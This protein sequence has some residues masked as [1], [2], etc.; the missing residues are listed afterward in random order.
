MKYLKKYKVFES[1]N[2]NF[3]WQVASESIDIITKILKLNNIKFK[4]S[5]LDEE[6]LENIDGDHD[7]GS[8][9]YIFEFIDLDGN[10]ISIH[11]A[12]QEKDSSE[13]ENDD[14]DFFTGQNVSVLLFN[15]N[16]P[17]EDGIYLECGKDLM[18]ELSKLE[19]PLPNWIKKI[20]ND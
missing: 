15:D 13:I 20:N 12:P 17:D 6:E 11:I 9:L 3:Y 8:E 4:H 2:N 16:T 10:G 19:L 18:N 5:H 1:S 14:D 7:S